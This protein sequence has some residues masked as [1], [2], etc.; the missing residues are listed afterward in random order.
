M[1]HLRTLRESEA[2]Q[3]ESEER[4]RALVFASTEGIIIQ[5]TDGRVQSAN[6]TAEKIFGLAADQMH[7]KT[8]INP[9]WRMIHADGSPFPADMFPLAVTLW[10]GKPCTNV[11]MGIQK[12]ANE[13][14]WVLVN[15]R[16]LQRPGE[17]K[18]YAAIA[19]FV[20]ISERR[21][22]E[23]ALHHQKQILEQIQDAVVVSDLDGRVK[24]WNKGAER[25]FGYGAMEAIGNTVVFL[26][27]LEDEGVLTKHTSALL[28]DKQGQAV[29]VWAHRRTGERC[30]IHLTTSLLRDEHG[31][32]YGM[33]GYA[34]DITELK[35][36]EEA[37]RESEGRTRLIVDTAMD[38]V[39]SIDASGKIAGWNAQAE[40]IFGWTFNEIIGKSLTETIIPV[41]QREAHARG[42]SEYLATGKAKMLNRRIETTGLRKNGELFPVELSTTAIL[43]PT[44]P[45]SFSAFLRDV[46]RR[47]HA[48]ENLRQSEERY[49]TLVE[50]MTDGLYRST[51]DGKFIEVNPALVKML[52]YESKRELMDIDIKTQ[53]YFTPQEREDMNE[54][55]RQTGKDEIEV[56][57]LRHKV[58]HEVWV[59]DHGR[60]VYDARGNVLFHEGILRDITA[61]LHA[62]KALRESEERFRTLYEDNPSM[63]FTVDANGIVLSANRSGAQQL[64]YEIDELVGKPV[65]N[66]FH[67]RDRASAMEH[68]KTC[69]SNS[70]KIHNWQIR[71][72][73]KDGSILWVRETA[74][75][76]RGVDD[77]RIVLIVCEDITDRKKA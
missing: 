58:G 52:G 15:S 35:R 53:L 16:P 21:R 7:G 70:D 61:R 50:R 56:F 17:N 45:L 26:Y 68:I 12:P 5:G 8:L 22:A 48:E 59:E 40:A 30:F 46:S 2:T 36:A 3:R 51:P 42:L 71:K 24:V 43:N 63:Y 13:V 65:V 39:I 75:A 37:L 20:D 18:A 19:S 72:V 25:I 64:G 77:Q 10:N 47:K 76:A 6:A 9:S 11:L 66:V 28:K 31:S 62:Q 57:R 41:E 32:P 34:T 54:I 44:G 23:E 74:R 55:L 27:A 49:R 69:L 73:R 1:R 67:E 4:Q 60:L 33:V 29:E 14:S 38:A